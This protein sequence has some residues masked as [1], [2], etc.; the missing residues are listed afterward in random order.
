VRA[1]AKLYGLLGTILVVLVLD[2]GLLGA[3]LFVQLRRAPP[4]P[5][6]TAK[7]DPPLPPASAGASAQT[8]SVSVPVVAERAIQWHDAP[9]IAQVG[10]DETEDVLGLFTTVGDDGK[11]SYFVGAFDGQTLSRLWRAGPIAVIERSDKAPI[12]QVAVGHL[13]A[14]ESNAIHLYGI[15][16]GEE[17]G[18]IHTNDR[19]TELCVYGPDKSKVWARVDGGKNVA[20]DIAL[21]ET[22]A[23]EAPPAGCWAPKPGKLESPTAPGFAPSKV[24]V[25]G[26]V[27]IAL[28]ARSP[29]M[30][31]PMAVGFD[32]KSK[33]IRWQHA[34]AESEDP[35]GVVVGA[36]RIAELT[37]GRLYASY[38]MQAGGWHLAAI[39][40]KAGDRA[41]EVPVPDGNAAQGTITVSPSRVYL[42]H[43]NWLDVFDKITGRQA[44]TLGDHAP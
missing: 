29:G 22:K 40:G 26:D 14:A 9:L 38:R 6:A 1:N 42:F 30:P 36:G 2:F 18:T 21:A 23:M 41:W 33:K 31:V 39:D 4:T 27:A 28:G 25:E 15:T 8:P 20:L 13:L 16:S 24:L 44:G 11:L 7:V 43:G 19:V 5:E 35:T 10:G 37:E 34:I 32:P 12:L 17:R 3:N